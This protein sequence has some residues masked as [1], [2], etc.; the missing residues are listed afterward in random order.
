VGAEVGGHVGVHV[1]ETVEGAQGQVEQEAP[2]DGEVTGQAPLLDLTHG[3]KGVS[4]GAS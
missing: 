4:A 2:A 3:A 1:A